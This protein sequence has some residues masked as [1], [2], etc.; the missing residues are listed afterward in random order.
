MA[1]L[2]RPLG[3]NANNSRRGRAGFALRVR[4]L[5]RAFLSRS[6]RKPTAGEYCQHA[7]SNR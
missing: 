3:L 6:S 5:P 1:G 4:A 7:P 2:F